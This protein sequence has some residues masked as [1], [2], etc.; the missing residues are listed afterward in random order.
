MFAQ[1]SGRWA[2]KGVSFINPGLQNQNSSSYTHRKV[3]IKDCCYS[4]FGT[5][6]HSRVL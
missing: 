3:V 6:T 2:K 4:L 1:I 5:D